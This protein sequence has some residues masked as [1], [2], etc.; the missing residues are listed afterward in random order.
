MLLCELEN[1]E[2]GCRAEGIED[3]EVFIALNEEVCLARGCKLQ[4]LIALWMVTACRQAQA[5]KVVNTKR[6]KATT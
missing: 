5:G 4:E 1:C 6:K 2:D 3:E